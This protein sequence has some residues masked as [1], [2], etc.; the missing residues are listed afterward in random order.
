[1]ARVSI[2]DCQKKLPNRFAL[3]MAAAHRARQLLN[4]AEPMIKDTNNKE[5]VVALR[6]IAEGLITAKPVTEQVWEETIDDALDP[7]DSSDP[8][9]LTSSDESS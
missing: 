6:E 7:D 5:I 1:M 2:E 4:Q 9:S 3:A 8:E